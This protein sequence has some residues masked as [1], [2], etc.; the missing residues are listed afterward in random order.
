MTR[1]SP[2]KPTV[3]A[4][5][6]VI[7]WAPEELVSGSRKR[8]L[9][10][11]EKAFFQQLD[12]KADFTLEQHYEQSHFGDDFSQNN[13][14]SQTAPGNFSV[15]RFLTSLAKPGP[16]GPNRAAGKWAYQDKTLSLMSGF[17]QPPLFRGFS[18]LPGEQSELGK[19]ILSPAS[20]R[21]QPYNHN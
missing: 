6:D 7:K 19:N 20:R 12:P 10:E 1:R 11:I 21:C 3:R 4:S 15:S 17:G 16:S 8:G 9:S 2:R 18:G 13:D 14:Q 5:D